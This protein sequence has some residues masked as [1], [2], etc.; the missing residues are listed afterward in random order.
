MTINA[1]LVQHGSVGGTPINVDMAR[2]E[3][4]FTKKVLLSSN[5]S[6]LHV[7]GMPSRPSFTGCAAA[8]LD[9]PRTVTSG[10]TLTLHAGEADA[11]VAAGA[12]TYA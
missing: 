9:Y 2:L 7:P 4:G 8:N 6:M 1:K 10:T 11:L 3:H 5:Y 12:G